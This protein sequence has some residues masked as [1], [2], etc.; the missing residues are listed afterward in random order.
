MR[1]RATVASAVLSMV[2]DEVGAS[3]A[4]VDCPPNPFASLCEPPDQ[5]DAAE[6]AGWARR[7][8]TR[9]GAMRG[10][11]SAG[12]WFVAAMPAVLVGCVK[13]PAP[14]AEAHVE[15]PGPAAAQDKLLGARVKA[16]GSTVEQ[17]VQEGER[18][19]REAVDA[20]Q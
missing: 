14:P 17:A 11:F 6:C 15:A 10:M 20:A 16:V 4:G 1:T 13:P 12:W 7:H 9:S 2:A 3:A 8:R 19:N 5:Q 18:R